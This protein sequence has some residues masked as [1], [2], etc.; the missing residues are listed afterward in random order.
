MI[1]RARKTNAVSQT[2]RRAGDHAA[3]LDWDT[4]VGDAFLNECV[5]QGVRAELAVDALGDASDEATATALR[6]V[7][8][9]ATRRAALGWLTIE[10]CFEQFGEMAAL[11]LERC[12]E[13][14]AVAT[15]SQRGLDPSSEMRPRTSQLVLRHR[16]EAASRIVKRG[17]ERLARFWDQNG[18]FAA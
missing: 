8:T 12:V 11:A 15:E 5:K 18:S 6:T 7:I 16:D 14:A 1:P 10:K 17:R 9:D 4:I 2:M 13:E 3:R